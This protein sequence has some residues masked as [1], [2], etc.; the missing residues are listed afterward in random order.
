MISK[1]QELISIIV[2]CFNSG[3]TLM[4]T[5]DSI[6][7]Q[8]WQNKEIILVNDGSNDKKTLEILNEIQKDNLVKIIYQ[9]N[10]CVYLFG[11]N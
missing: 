3:K 7:N 9:K 8:S 6:R 4:R 5:I 2:P 11:I 1:N 10:I